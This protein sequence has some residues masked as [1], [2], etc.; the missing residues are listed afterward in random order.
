MRSIRYAIMPAFA[1]L[2]AALALAFAP[3]AGAT[4]GQQITDL[5]GIPVNVGSLAPCLPFDLVITGNGHDHFVFSN[6]GFHENAT[7]EG[8]G[9][10]GPYSGHAEAW[11]TSNGKNGAQVDTFKAML[12]LTQGTKIQQTGTFVLNAN[13]VP[14]VGNLKVSCS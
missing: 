4:T 12:Q 2:A 3:A 10:A 5:T 1:G 9:V 14:V 13:G 11:F 6:A 8:T 7:V